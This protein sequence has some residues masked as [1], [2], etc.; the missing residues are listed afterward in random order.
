MYLRRWKEEHAKLESDGLHRQVWERI[1]EMLL[2]RSR[3]EYVQMI[4]RGMTPEQEQ[5]LRDYLGMDSRKSAGDKASATVAGAPSP[6]SQ[7]DS[8]Q[9]NPIESNHFDPPGAALNLN[10]ATG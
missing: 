8:I 2:F 10:A 9:V 5:R 3:E 6:A 7:S 4:S 1:H